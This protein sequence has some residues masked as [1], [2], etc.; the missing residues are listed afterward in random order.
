MAKKDDDRASRPD[1]ENP[2]WT[3]ADFKKG[4]ARA[5]GVCRDVRPRGRRSHQEPR[6]AAGEGGQKGEVV[7]PFFLQ[8]LRLDPDVLVSYKQLGRGWQTRMNDVLREHAPSNQ[9]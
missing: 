2:E 1:D 3:A 8:T 5:D 4:T 6:R 9:K 7:I